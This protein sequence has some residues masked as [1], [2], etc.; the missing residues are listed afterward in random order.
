MTFASRP[1]KKTGFRA[2]KM[3]TSFFAT[4]VNKAVPRQVMFKKIVAC[5]NGAKC[6][7]YAIRFTIDN[8]AMKEDKDHVAPNQVK[9]V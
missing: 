7:F 3:P 5:L 6:K 2:A 4:I 9:L 1:Q 8:V